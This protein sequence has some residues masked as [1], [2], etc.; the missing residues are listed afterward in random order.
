MLA[1]APLSAPNAVLAPW[2]P[3]YLPRL[4]L[5]DQDS[6]LWR[7][8]K[9]AGEAGIVI[10]GRHLLNS[11]E[12]Q[13]RLDW[14]SSISRRKIICAADFMARN[15]NLLE[16]DRVFWYREMPVPNGWHEAYGQG[17]ATTEAYQLAR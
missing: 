3:I 2:P 7:T 16:A 6:A 5:E 15:R 12:R 17:E 9:L 1:A 10:L 14:V 4:T 8:L 11:K 13:Q